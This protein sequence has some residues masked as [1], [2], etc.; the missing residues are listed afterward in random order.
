MYSGS[1]LCQATTGSKRSSQRGARVDGVER[2]PGGRAHGAARSRG[3]L[4]RGEVVEDRL[5]HQEVR[6]ARPRACSSSA[7]R[8]AAS[9]ERSTS[10]RSSSSPLGRARSRRTGSRLLS[11]RRGSRRNGRGRSSSAH[12]LARIHWRSPRQRVAGRDR[13]P[14]GECPR[15]DACAAAAR[16]PRRRTEAARRGSP[17][18]GSSVVALAGARQAA[19]RSA[20]SS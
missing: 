15:D 16:A 14:L 13:V 20:I 11:Q 1:G 17:H 7:M 8:S 18:T 19:Y 12:L 2:R 3:A 6:R 4:L 9:S 10:W 5:G